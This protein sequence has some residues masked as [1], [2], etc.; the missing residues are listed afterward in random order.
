MPRLRI[1]LRELSELDELAD[2]LEELQEREGRE[3]RR[4]EKDKR[5]IN[6]V[7]FQRRQD[8]RKFGKDIAR[9]LRERKSE[10]P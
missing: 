8:Q 3:E 1:N 4:D 2:E 10:K 6:P 9:L 7:A 5:I